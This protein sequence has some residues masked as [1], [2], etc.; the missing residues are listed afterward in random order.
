MVGLGMMGHSIAQNLMNKGFEMV[1][2][3]IRPEAMTDLV[4]QG[5]EAA[6]NLPALGEKADPILLM[7]NTAD[8][9][10]S[11]MHPLMKTMRN[12]TL[13]NLGTMSQEDVLSLEKEAEA[14]GLAMLDCPVSGGVAGAKAGELT[15]LA[16]GS[17]ELFDK[18]LPVLQA[19]SKKVFHVG[20][21]AGD[22]QAVKAINQLLVGIHMCATAEAFTLAEKCGLDL[23][24]VYETICASAGTSHI[25]EN[26][27]RFL[28]ERNFDT[29]STLQIMLKD[30]GIACQTADKTGSPLLLGN[31]VRE[32]FKL[33]AQKY[34]PTEDALAVAKLYEELAGLEFQK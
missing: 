3:D 30:T 24:T 29:R 26:R 32:I 5:A 11:V 34:I 13:I 23:N 12:G 27:G 1:L 22:G 7:V 4:E 10:R 2:Y 15:V 31:T 19:F 25:F 33:S 9:C 28:I 21:H 16:S 6:E 20:P 14:A 18:Y 17:D 8:Q